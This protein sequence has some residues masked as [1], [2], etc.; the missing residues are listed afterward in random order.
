MNLAG[1]PWVCYILCCVKNFESAFYFCFGDLL[2]DQ[3]WS[4][5]ECVIHPEV[6]L[7]GWRDAK[8]PRTTNFVFAKIIMPFAV[9]SAFKTNSQ[10]TIN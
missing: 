4:N 8:N 5:C 9:D 10:P 7:C 2:F 6:T 1:S 3:V